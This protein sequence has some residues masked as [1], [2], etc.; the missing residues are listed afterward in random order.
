MLDVPWM[1]GPHEI[2]LEDLVEVGSRRVRGEY[3]AD[4][5]FAIA[6]GNHG[7]PELADLETVE[8]VTV[9]RRRVGCRSIRRSARARGEQR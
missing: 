7:G 8:A 2:R 5:D 9:E 1:V 3:R 4:R 6:V